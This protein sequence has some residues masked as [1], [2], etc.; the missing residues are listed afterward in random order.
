MTTPNR[1]TPEAWV[2]TC[3]CGQTI[4][5]VDRLR[6][7][8]SEVSAALTGWL[9]RGCTIEPRWGSFSASISPCTCEPATKGDG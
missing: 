7:P 5:A 8:A 4:G 9:H 3:Q 2:A 6:S 1:G